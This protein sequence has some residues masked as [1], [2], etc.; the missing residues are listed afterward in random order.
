MSYKCEKGECINRNIKR[1]IIIFLFVLFTSGAITS[2]TYADPKFNKASVKM[3]KNKRAKLKLKGLSSKQKK[4][5]WSFTSSDKSVVTVKRTSKT[6]CRITTKKK[7]G[8]AVVRAKQGHVVTYMLVQVGNGG[9]PTYTRTT[10]KWAAAGNLL[11]PEQSKSKTQQT[12]IQQTEIQQTESAQSLENQSQKKEEETE[13]SPSELPGYV[14]ENVHSALGRIREKTGEGCIAVPI[15]T[16]IHAESINNV[17]FKTMMSCIRYMSEKVHFDGLFSL[18]DE[19]DVFLGRSGHKTNAEICSVL[20]Q[21]H[22]TV[23]ETCR[24]PFMPLN[25]NHDGIGAD[26]FNI[27]MW[28]SILRQN[29]FASNVVR[30]ENNAYYYVDYPSLKF[31]IVCMSIPSSSVVDV[32]H[33]YVVWQ[34]G[35][36][37]LSWLAHKALKTGDGY[38]VALFVHVPTCYNYGDP[39]DQYNTPVWDGVNVKMA[40]PVQITGRVDDQSSIEGIFSAYHNHTTF[41]DSNIACDFSNYTSTRVAVE[42]AGHTHVD[43]VIEPGQTGNNGMVNGMPCRVISIASAGYYTG[44]FPNFSGGVSPVRKDGTSSEVL[45]DV[46][47]FDLNKHKLNLIRVGAGSDVREF[48]F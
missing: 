26:F 27:G 16:D 14:T 15:Y 48:Y 42:L 4:R 23:T 34:A 8:Y 46:A 28:D 13:E 35:N 30:E 32:E 6:S 47:V 24:L 44:I 25:G 21:F 17:R 45:F 9:K 5:R 38:S 29:Q 1:I 20:S 43:C 37:Q 39:T 33:P 12:E 41:F 19:I 11:L 7:N 36:E 3:K 18:G 22:K 10:K 31:R 40:D 2:V